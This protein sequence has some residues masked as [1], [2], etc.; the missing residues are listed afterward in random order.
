MAA[1][2]QEAKKEGLVIVH[3]HDSHKHTSENIMNK[4][5]RLTLK[6]LPQFLIKNLHEYN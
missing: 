2:N 4:K 6:I 3:R 1:Q 5:K